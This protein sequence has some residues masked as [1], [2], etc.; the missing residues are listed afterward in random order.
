M[1]GDVCEKEKEGDLAGNSAD[2]VK[3]L[4]LD[5]FIAFKTEVLLETSDIGIVYTLLADEGG[6]M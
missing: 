6:W 4:Q 3:C 5:E 1:D 2:D